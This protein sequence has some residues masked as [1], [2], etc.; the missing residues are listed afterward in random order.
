MCS[1]NAGEAPGPGH[2]FQIPDDDKPAVD[3]DPAASSSGGVV[4][5]QEAMVTPWRGVPRGF[6]VHCIFITLEWIESQACARGRLISN[7][8]SF[9]F[10]QTLYSLGM[11][12]QILTW[13][14][15][16]WAVGRESRASVRRPY[17]YFK[18]G[19]RGSTRFVL[20]T[21]SS[22]RRGS[23]MGRLCLL[24]GR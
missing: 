2:W 6:R 22:V 3:K 10:R 4:G 14:T 9:I 19:F 24:N 7:L 23:W 15:R 12:S 18:S 11:E 16:Y 21:G 8:T 1:R 20:M 17:A 13:W 5:A